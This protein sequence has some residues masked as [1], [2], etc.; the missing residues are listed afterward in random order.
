MSALFLDTNIISDMMRDL[1]GRAATRA[2][3]A[4]IHRGDEALFT[5]TVVQCEL[6]YGLARKPSP[7]LQ[8]AYQT[9]MDSI[10]VL[11]LDHTVSAHYA[12]LRTHLEQAGTPIGGN[13]MLIAA[14]ALSLGATLVTADAEFSRVPGLMLE[15]WLLPSP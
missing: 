1:Q 14:H 8:L 6:E 15:N 13:D 4:S 7:R 10:E 2:K 9:V 12:N 11:P 3:Q 5:S